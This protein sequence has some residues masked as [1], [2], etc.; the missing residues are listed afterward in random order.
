M[1]RKAWIC[2]SVCALIAVFCIAAGAVQYQFKG[3]S[4]R[5]IDHIV[6]AD[7]DA[8]L[9]AAAI[10]ED[11]M[12]D[13][14][15]VSH[16]PLVVIN[17]GGTEIKSYKKYNAETDAFEI[18]EGIDPYYPMEIWVY[19]STEHCNRLTDEAGLKSAGRIK[20]RGNSSASDSLPKF[21]YTLKL[22]T[23]NG[24]EQALDMMGMGAD[25]TWILSPT[26]RDASRVRNYIA[27]NIAGQIEPFQPDLRY[28]EVLFLDNGEYR[29][30]G[31]YMMCESVKVSPDRVDIS[32]DSSKYHVGQGYLL[33]KDRYDREA[34][35]LHT[36]ATEQ[37]DY[38]LSTEENINRS[39]FMLE[40]PKNE[41]VTEE[42]IEN[43]TA[44]LSQIEKKL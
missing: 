13:A 33:R 44:E 25:D 16:L 12:V 36:W 2:A 14:N 30:E 26:V 31:L 40:Y 5:Y 29:Y 34:V 27:Y 35:T 24:E 37:G 38:D 21:Q 10:P 23:E 41:N 22:E 39:F 17:T 43:I 42:V 11:R 7:A 18:P 4:E 19:D 32:R 15:F 8:S 9:G 3:R 1:K 6:N 20:V 28:C